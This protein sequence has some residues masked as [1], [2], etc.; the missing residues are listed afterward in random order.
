MIFE[1]SNILSAIQPTFI[2]SKILGLRPAI[3]ILKSGMKIKKFGYIYSILLY[4][5][6]MIIYFS[7]GQRSYMKFFKQSIL[8]KAS[9]KFMEFG[10]IV[11]MTG[12]LGISCYNQRGLFKCIKRIIRIDATLSDMNIRV[13]YTRAKCVSILM[14]CIICVFDILLNYVIILSFSNKNDLTILIPTAKLFL[15]RFIVSQVVSEFLIIQMILHDHFKTVNYKIATINEE[16]CKGTLDALFPKRAFLT[17]INNLNKTHFNIKLNALFDL[18]DE[19]CDLCKEINALYS[20]SLLIITT[21]A[22]ADTTINLYVSTLAFIS[23]DNK[24]FS[25]AFVANRIYRTVIN[26]GIFIALSAGSS[27]T[28]N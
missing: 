7:S 11:I 3:S 12:I 2:L 10:T 16:M 4:L 20:L 27:F 5:A 8:V 18:H 1:T 13:S 28:A 24:T 26:A 25:V 19:L 6:Y 22:F 15:P 17:K 21:L 14:I 23:M 9:K